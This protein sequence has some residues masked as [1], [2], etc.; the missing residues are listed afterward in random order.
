MEYVAKMN[1]TNAQRELRQLADRLDSTANNAAEA[2]V[3]IDR[4]SPEAIEH[5]MHTAVQRAEGVLGDLRAL[6]GRLKQVR[7]WS[8]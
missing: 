4:R 2:C 8:S 7:R 5:H 6:T 3:L 1:L